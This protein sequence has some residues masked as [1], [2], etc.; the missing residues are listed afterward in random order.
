MRLLSD[1]Y[2]RLRNGSDVAALRFRNRLDEN[3]V[4]VTLT[5][6]DY[7]DQEDAGTDKDLDLY[8]EDWAGRRVGAGEKTQVSGARVPGPDESRNPRERVVLNDLPASPVI[9]TDPDYTYRI[10]VRAKKGQFTPSDRIRILLTASHDL[11]LP[12]GAD[13]PRE[14]VEF[15][16]ATNGGELYPPADHPLVLT[17]GDSAPDSGVGP[18]ADRRV[19]PDVLLDDSRTYFSDG[20]VSAGSSNAAA[21]VAGVVA[22]LKAAQPTLRMRHLL[23]LAHQ[24]PTVPQPRNSGRH[25][26]PP[27]PRAPSLAHPNPG[28][29]R[30]SGPRGTLRRRP[31]ARLTGR[32]LPQSLSGGHLRWNLG[33]TSTTYGFPLRVRFRGPLSLATTACGSA[34]C[35]R[36]TSTTSRGCRPPRPR[37]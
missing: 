23:L 26:R 18:T 11:Y 10:R 27:G 8:V 33:R 24:G 19:K 30:R 12:P 37:G 28:Q 25:A 16:D 9:A 1:G 20:Q 6:N 15:L 34:G 4:T 17:V 35:A 32:P 29:A 21:Y 14:A 22:L 7:R 3:T 5:W 13:G 31:P 36:R 2:L